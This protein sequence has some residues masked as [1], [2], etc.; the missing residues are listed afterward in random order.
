ML[1]ASS[2]KRRFEMIPFPNIKLEQDFVNC[3]VFIA[4]RKLY[5]EEVKNV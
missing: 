4:E 2:K 5:E 3:D 1:M